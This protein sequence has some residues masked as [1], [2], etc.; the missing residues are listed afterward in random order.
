MGLE[1]S[2]WWGSRFGCGFRFRLFPFSHF[3][4][5]SFSANF[6][7]DFARCLRR[8]FGAHGLHPGP[9]PASLLDAAGPGRHPCARRGAKGA[10]SWTRG[11]GAVAWLKAFFFG[12]SQTVPV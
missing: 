2:V 8:R 6:G 5:L 7:P 9:L 3:V 12:L 4:N 11:A 10:A 1:L